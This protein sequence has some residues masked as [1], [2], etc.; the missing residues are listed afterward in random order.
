MLVFWFLD[1]KAFV[2]GFGSHAMGGVWKHGTAVGTSK[3][4]KQRGGRE[5]PEIWNSFIL[6]SVLTLNSV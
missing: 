2:H 6:A 1:V 4:Q 5:Y 3:V